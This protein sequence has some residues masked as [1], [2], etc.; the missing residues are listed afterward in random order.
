M[1]APHRRHHGFQVGVDDG[2]VQ[3]AGHGHHQEI[4]VHQGPGGQ[5]EGDVG[6]PQH[7]LEAQLLF[8]PGQGLQCLGGRRL[9]R[10]HG[11]GETVDVHV[12]PPN[13]VVQRPVQDAPGDIQPVQGGLGDAVLVQGQSHHRRAVL[14]HQRQNGVQ[15]LLVPVHRI[16]DGFA[17]AD[18]QRL[19]QHLGPGRVQLEGGVCHPLEGLD[20][21]D[22][23]GGFVNLRQAHVHVQNV[24]PGLG[25]LQ[26]LGE[27]EVHVVPEKGLLHPLLA[28]GVDAL[29]DHPHP[30]DG[31]HPGGTAYRCGDMPG[32]ALD[33]PPLQGRTHF[34]DVLRGGAAAAAV[35]LHPQLG[36]LSHRL[37]E[38]IRRD[39]VARPARVGQAG[40]GLYRDGQGGPLCQ[41]PHQPGHLPGT[42]GA[43]DSNHVRP[44][45]LQGK[46][47]AGR[48]MAQEGASPL[49][50]GEGD[51]HRQG[52][53]LLHRQQGGP[54][55]L[56]I[57][58]GLNLH[59]VHPSLHPA[60]HLL[61]ENIHRSLK[62]Q[63]PSGLQQL[64]DGAQVQ[65]HQGFPG[66][67]LPGNG[68]GGRDDLLHR[69]SSAFQLL[70]VGPEGAGA[71][72]L[73][74]RLHVG[75]VNLQQPV[76][77]VQGGQLGVLP[78]LKSLGLE[79]GAHAA[80]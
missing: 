52:A 44:H 19:L 45:A 70:P 69:L 42:Q 79:H 38:L 47:G 48:G 63:R 56:E 74:P 30:V 58:H 49:L 31:H 60:A 25:L 61:G 71:E 41:L 78:Q 34:G 10:R 33:C 66:G 13:S 32:H 7:R 22:H 27:H 2:Q 55:L 53:V 68:D 46:G 40:V 73:R 28:G 5:A 80:V 21:L 36:E 14:F 39:V 15:R 4:L 37:G 59:Q 77:M 64:P 24:R 26:G 17:A 29:A 72:N 65:G 20:H 12:L 3:A 62:I 57:G 18:P 11:K 67:G 16:D 54:A 6:H 76:R 1:V 35:A 23:H 50:I 8:H 9:L 51:D 75:A 43:V